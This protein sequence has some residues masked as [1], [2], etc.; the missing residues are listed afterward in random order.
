MSKSYSTLIS[1]KTNTG[2]SYQTKPIKSKK[3]IKDLAI[4]ECKKIIYQKLCKAKPICI[5]PIKK[6]EIEYIFK[7]FKI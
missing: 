5:K 1:N 7:Q 4:E 3:N 2:F 6:R